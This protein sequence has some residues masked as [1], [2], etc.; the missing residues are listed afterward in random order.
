MKDKAS[1]MKHLNAPAGSWPFW[2]ASIMAAVIGG[3]IG[4]L[5]AL[6]GQ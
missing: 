2:K 3:A 5:L 1:T 6:V 4:A